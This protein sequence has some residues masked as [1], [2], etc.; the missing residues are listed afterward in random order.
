LRLQFRILNVTPAQYDFR[1]LSSFRNGLGLLRIV[2]IV[3]VSTL[4][5][6]YPPHLG[7]EADALNHDL[8][9]PRQH[10]ILA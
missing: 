8:S 5:A 2:V 1:L 6:V 10:L 9:L 3:A 7:Q 4:A